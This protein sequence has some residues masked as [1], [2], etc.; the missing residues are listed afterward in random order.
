MHDLP[1][2]AD[3]HQLVDLYP[4]FQRVRTELME[5]AE[6]LTNKTIAERLFVAPSTVKTHLSN[7]FTKLDVSTR[8]ELTAEAVR[9]TG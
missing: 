5:V 4:I 2:L 1:H 8:S 3:V 6:G 7:V 9:Q